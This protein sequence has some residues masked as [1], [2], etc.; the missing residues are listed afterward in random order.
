MNILDERGLF[1]WHDEPLPDRQ[2]APDS[3]V[4]GHLII[5]EHGLSHLELE[6]GLTV[7]DKFV[8]PVMDDGP[9]IHGKSIKGLLKGG[10]NRHIVLCELSRD[11]GLINTAG[12]SYERYLAYSCIASDV[13]FHDDEDI[14]HI[15]SLQIN[16]QGFEEWL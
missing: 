15:G 14:S 11:G 5:D 10:D 6:G 2:F 8:S 1:W 13:T 16:L 3:C 9:V 4:P 7:G 12:L